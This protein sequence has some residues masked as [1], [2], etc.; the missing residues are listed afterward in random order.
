MVHYH[1]GI[2]YERKR[3]WRDAIR[4]FSQVVSENPE[5]AS[6]HFH[7]GLAYKRLDLRDLA[8]GEFMAALNLD[9]DDHASLEQLH[10]L[11][12]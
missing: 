11:Q 6:S 9:G 12:E 10:S 4:E 2:I 3:M 5:A 7:L 1:L 8:V